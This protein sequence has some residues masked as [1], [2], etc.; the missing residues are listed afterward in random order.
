[1]PISAI[2]RYSSGM[3]CPWVSITTM[4][5]LDDSKFTSPARRAGAVKS[6][7]PKIRICVFIVIYL[8][9]LKAEIKKIRPTLNSFN[10]QF[11]T[12]TIKIR[13]RQ[14]QI[15]GGFRIGSDLTT[16]KLKIAPFQIPFHLAPRNNIFLIPSETILG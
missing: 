4:G 7:R 10:T 1:M 11:F 12:H 6:K 2:M 8:L 9:L 13:W 3:V 5:R 16:N 15:S 14:T